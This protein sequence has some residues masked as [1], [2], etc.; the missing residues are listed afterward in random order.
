MSGDW[1]ER[2]VGAMPV[3]VADE[4]SEYPLELAAV[5]DQ[6]PVQTFSSRSPNP[7]LDVGI[8]R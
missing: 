5:E 1:S 6:E 4:D 2:A 7:A 8:S 3:V